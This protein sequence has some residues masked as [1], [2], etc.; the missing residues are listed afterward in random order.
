VIVALTRIILWQGNSFVLLSL[1]MA[2]TASFGVIAFEFEC[3][4]PFA[5]FA[6]VIGLT[7][8][9]LIFTTRNIP[10]REANADALV[11]LLMFWAIIPA[12]A[13]FPLLVSDFIDTP[14][15]AYFETVSALTTTGASSL[16]PGILPQTYHVWRSL[17]QWFGGIVSATFAIVILAALDSRGTDVHKS[18]L[19]TLK[20]G[21]IFERLKVIGGAVAGLYALIS[22]GTFVAM[23][24]SGTP[25]F[26]SLCLALSSVATGGFMPRSDAL[27]DYVDHIGLFALMLS[28]L[29]GGF[30]VVLVW[31]ML[32]SRALAP[33]RAFL[34]DA[35]HRFML[36]IIVILSV[37]GFMH[38]GVSHVK[39]IFVEAVFF[40]SSAGFNFHVMGLEMIPPIILIAIAL[41]GGSALSTAG[42]IKLIRLVLLFRHLKTDFN[43]LS[44][45]SRLVPVVFRGEILPDSALLSIWMYFFGYT[46]VFAVG[47]MALSISGL[48][49][50]QSVTASAAF[51]SNMGP[52]MEYTL[53]LEGYEVFSSVQMSVG[54]MLMLIGRVEVLAVLL[55]LLPGFWR[56]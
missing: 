39:A 56:R 48:S 14:V 17:L 6:A 16:D 36:S 20:R 38:L 29:L 53:P 30:N 44:H 24:I 40:A 54:T 1:L 33:I 4:V 42:G 21:E 52:L 37:I 12:L 49:F 18:F 27:A 43:R 41:I 26:D 22:F 23:T 31:D 19:F 3:A 28:C 13:T 45:P 15:R 47:I 51:L 32:R 35:E 9:I 7:G 11:F 50:E 46:L 8:I 2:L 5:V 55:I 34:Y 10:M 25:I